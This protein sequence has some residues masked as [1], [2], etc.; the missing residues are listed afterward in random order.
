MFYIFEMSKMFVIFNGKY[1][2][3][4]VFFLHS[5]LVEK[6]QF[7]A[8]RRKNFTLFFTLFAEKRENRVLHFFLHLF[9]REAAKIFMFYTR[10]YTLFIGKLVKIMVYTLFFNTFSPRS[11]EKF[12]T[13]FFTLYLLE[14]RNSPIFFHSFFCGKIFFY[15]PKK[16]LKKNTD[17]R[18]FGGVLRL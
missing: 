14:K 6:C 18:P 4:P 10:F 17:W 2:F 11:G 8:K 5:F 3:V 15:T 1:E 12:Y 7:A 9:R 16:I 13:T